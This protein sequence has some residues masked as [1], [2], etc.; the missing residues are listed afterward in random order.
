[1]ISLVEEVSRMGKRTDWQEI[2]PLGGGGQSDVLLVRTPTRI[3]GRQNSIDKL[4]KL[5]A[6]NLDNKTAIDFAEA[7]WNCARP[8]L[9]S[10]RGALK[11]FKIPAEGSTLPPPPGSA[12]SESIQRL[13]NEIAALGLRLSGLPKLL[14]FNEGERW[15]VTEYFPERTLEHH[16]LRYKG[17]AA[18][19]LRAFRSLVQ[20]VASLHDKG[21][22][23]RDIKPANIFVK[24]DDELVL[25]DFGI[26][27]V[28]NAPDRLTL[29]G[30]RVGPR[31]YMPPWAN[32][33]A[34]HQD[35]HPRDDVYMLGKLLW[36]MVAGHAVLPREY[37][38]HPDYE[39]DLTRTFPNEPQMH[40]I[41][42]ILDKCVV[43]Q[44]DQ[45]LSG[46]QDLL[47][48]IDQALGIIERGGQLLR[49]GVP[50]P[51]RVCGKGFYQAVVLR[52]NPKNGPLSLRFWVIGTSDI[53]S[54]PARPLACDYCG[55]VELF[56]TSPH[57]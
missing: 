28:P 14:D 21:Y 5:S 20:T 35:V 37:H 12:Q 52:E 2:E 46:A 50:R 47:P 32:L 43:E 24:N 42:A 40:L 8:E 48:R 51:C 10:E 9:P 19:A 27:Y 36:S 44:A 57:H 29:T 26:V 16:P 54:V 34:R 4:K 38:K 53:S 7:A 3:A 13:K 18:L 1:M 55:H 39:F 25:S 41:N 30:E 15:V 33:G 31:D 45:C 11:L 22:V 23:H 49:P 6:Q 56:T 17:R